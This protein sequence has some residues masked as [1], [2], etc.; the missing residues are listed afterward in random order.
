MLDLIKRRDKKDARSVV[1]FTLLA[2]FKDHFSYR[3]NILRF[4]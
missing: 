3:Y 1:Y 4:F 2:Q